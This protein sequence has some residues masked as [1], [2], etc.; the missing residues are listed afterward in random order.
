ME[1]KNDDFYAVDLISS[2]TGI[3]ISNLLANLKLASFINE[4]DAEIKQKNAN[5]NYNDVIGK[6]IP[7]KRLN[8]N[9]NITA[10][11]SYCYFLDYF[12]MRQVGYILSR[13]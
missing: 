10:I 5:S 4:N 13:I 2:D 7:M 3:S 6:Y 9:E 11:L 1:I 8:E 12:Y